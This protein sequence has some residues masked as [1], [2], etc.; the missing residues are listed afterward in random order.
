MQQNERCAAD[1]LTEWQQ[2]Q[3]GR[4]THYFGQMHTQYSPN[5]RTILKNRNHLTHW[6]LLLTKPTLAVPIVTV[7]VITG[8][9]SIAMD[10]VVTFALK[11]LHTLG[12]TLKGIHIECW[13]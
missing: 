5:N 10:V 7:P 6:V 12:Q 2:P 4:F 1:R 8:I 13:L 11:Y 9:P 3:I